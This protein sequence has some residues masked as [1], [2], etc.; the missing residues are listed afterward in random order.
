LVQTTDWETFP[1][2][3]TLSYCWGRDEFIKLTLDTLDSF[4]DIV[5]YKDLPETFKDAIHIAR[6]LGLEY[7]WIDALC[8]IQGKD[9]NGDW[10]RESGRMR[11]VYGSAFVNIAASSATNVYE[12]C[13]SKPINYS[14]GFLARVTTSQFSRVQNF[15]S[16][17]VYEQSTSATHLASRAW[18]FQEKLLAPR[19]IYF[20]NR[21]LFWEC[22]STTASEFL[23]D[24]FT[25]EL[26]SL[27]KLVCPEDEAWRWDMI[28]RSYSRAQLTY[29]ADKL[30]ALSGVARRQHEV[31]GGEYLAGMWKEMLIKQL[32][33]S[34]SSK[35]KRP[36]WRAPSWSWTSIDAEISYWP[37]WDHDELAKIEYAQV[38]NAT[39]M[40]AG[41]D[42]FGA[43]SDGELRLRCAGMVRGRYCE[44]SN[45]ENAGPGESEDDR[46]MLDVETREFP[47]IMD[48][49][50]DSFMKASDPIYLL[51]LFGGETGGGPELMICG[52]VL[53]HGGLTK[54]RYRRVGSFDFR[55]DSVLLRTAES[56]RLY[57]SG[58]LR[59]LEEVG[60]STA[61]SE[62]TEII[63]DAEHPESRYVITIV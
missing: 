26:V 62:C 56:Q 37:G 63:L 58:F 11:T 50:Q 59:A 47:V 18:T 24:G 53:Q 46:V 10:S 41:S 52:I 4:L 27:S 44:P 25:K 40:L 33:W 31:T 30:P 61:E 39:T 7:I 23:P 16:C 17:E 21:G 49:L 43:V 1:R 29:S 15:H 19:T 14:G 20:G 54:G 51:P 60:A 6:R 2:Y 42:T 35:N 57:Y 5:P 45:A 55:R 32:S 36:N 3:A 38:L 8:I 28:V 22:R 48:C 13:L 12:G 34:P 9:D